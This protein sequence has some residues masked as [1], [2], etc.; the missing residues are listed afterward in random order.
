MVD[1]AVMIL[2][3]GQGERL[4]ILS[5]QRAKPA[6]PFAG[7]Y[8]IIDFTLS[9]C[10][11]S[12]YFDVAVLTQYRPHSLNEHIGHGRP[13]DLDRERNGGVVILQP[14]LGRSQ[15]G[16]YRGTA[17][18][19]YHNLFFVTRKPYTDVLILSGDHVYAMDYRPMVAQHRRLDADVTVA[20][21]PVPWEDASRFGLMT[22]DDEGRIIDFEEKPE[23]PRSNLAS[24]GIY[25]F[26][27]D[28]LLDLF[29]SPTYAE[30]MT[31]FGHH[32]IPYL[33]HHGRAYA[34]RFEGYWQD[35]GT[36]QSYWEANMALLEDVP[37]LNL[38][39]P[40]WRIHTRSEERPPAKI[41]D[42]SVVSRSLISHGAIIIRGRVEHSVLSPGVVVHEGAV[43]RDSIIMTDAVIGPGAVIDRCII[44]K[45]VRVG[46][47]AYLGYG[48]DYTPNWLEPKRVNTGITIVGR[49]AIVPSNVRI[50]RNVLIGTDVTEADFPTN[51][52]PSGDTI[53]PR[54]AAFW[55]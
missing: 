30:E 41:M 54:V 26:K 22:I 28:V 2:A 47:G 10:V 25:V 40:N 14:Y 20:V 53:D 44:D 48:D 52:I 27:R 5:R 35:V 23:Q 46:A 21:Q 51:E 1:V 33:I 24:M 36:I 43:V 55:S 32:F 13:W 9:N 19:I 29:R 7:K 11:N 17:D 38:Y 6:V 45:E 16:W 12:G 34:Y 3:G 15:S 18:A 31:D 8:R 50:G 37:A 4:S 39:D 49:N 42:G